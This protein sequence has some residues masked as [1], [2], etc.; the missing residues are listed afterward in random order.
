MAEGPTLGR[1][2]AHPF[3][4]PISGRECVVHLGDGDDVGIEHPD[5]EYRAE[6]TPELDCFFCR[7]C[8][9]NG[10]ISGAWFVDLLM[11]DHASRN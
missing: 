3:T 8:K 1:V 7:H 6:V 4:D 2:T 5:C 10:R 9:H 11:A